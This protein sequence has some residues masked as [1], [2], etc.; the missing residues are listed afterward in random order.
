MLQRDRDNNPDPRP[1]NHNAQNRTP[2]TFVMTRRQ[3]GHSSL[4]GRSRGWINR[5][6]LYILLTAVAA[7]LAILSFADGP[8]LAA[9]PST[10]LLDT[11]SFLS[12]I[13]CHRQIENRQ[14]DPSDPNREADSSP[15]KE[16]T[17]FQRNFFISLHNRHFDMMRWNS[18]YNT[19]E[20]YEKGLATQ[21]EEILKDKP[22]GLVMDVGMNIG[23]FTLLSR[24]WGHHVLGVDPNPIMHT[25]V[26]E[27]LKLN[28]WI[29]DGS[30][31][32][33]QYGMSDKPGMLNLTLGKNPGGSS[34]HEDRLAK[35]FR[36]QVP[37]AVTTLDK[38]AKQE[39]TLDRPV[40]LLKVDVEGFEAFVFRGASEI[41][42]SGR[43][44]NIILESSTKDLTLLLDLLA[45]IYHSG[46]DIRMISNVN[47]DPYHPEMIPS[48]L[49]ELKASQPGAGLQFLSTVTVNLWWT[50]R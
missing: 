50:K 45:K 1:P 44:G 43:V 27:S 6:S 3:L 35:K 37:V 38:I 2:S 40:H 23:W 5:S 47:G 13:D 28:H 7:V 22:P 20:Y 21:F 10:L 41:L 16:I 14:N 11:D 39:W 9:P 12:P 15:F 29:D 8:I 46:Y 42:K 4:K 36:R 25:R 33:F 17:K 19:G 31:R 26:C 24:Q 48:L 49:E 34:F 32:L 30:V 18:I